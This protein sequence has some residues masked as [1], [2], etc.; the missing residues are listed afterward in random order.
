[1][2]DHQKHERGQQQHQDLPPELDE[3]MFDFAFLRGVI[4]FRFSARMDARM[5]RS[6]AVF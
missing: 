1:M 4:G 3:E 2:G 6:M 5:D